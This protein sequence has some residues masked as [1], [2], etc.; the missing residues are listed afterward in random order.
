MRTDAQIASLLL[1]FTLPIR[2][3]GWLVTTTRGEG[4]VDAT[5]NGGNL[6]PID[7]E[8]EGLFKSKGDEFV[9]E[10]TEVSIEE[11]GIESP[12][13]DIDEPPWMRNK[14]DV[15]SSTY[16]RQAADPAQVDSVTDESGGI[17]TNTSNLAVTQRGV[18]SEKQEE[19][20]QIIARE[21]ARQRRREELFRPHRSDPPDYWARETDEPDSPTPGRNQHDDLDP[22]GPGTSGPSIGGV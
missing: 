4:V 20:D 11:L 12:G 13:E 22:D 7:D 17:G 15:K 8:I 1:A 5:G 14:R 21:E 6:T 3:Y 2:R 19:I 9:V 16:E 18:S 10:P